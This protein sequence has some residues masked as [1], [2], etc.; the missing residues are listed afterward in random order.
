MAI[1][2]VVADA[3]MF[4][5]HRE[6]ITAAADAGTVYSVKSVVDAVGF[7]CP[8]IL[9]ACGIVQPP[10]S[11]NGW[12]GTNDNR[13]SFKVPDVRSEAE[14]DPPPPPPETVAGTQAEPFHC[15]TWLVV[16]PLCESSDSECVWADGANVEGT[17]ERDEYAIVGILAA[18]NVPLVTADA[19][20]AI[21]VEPAVVKRPFASTVNVATLD[22]EP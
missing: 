5:M 13:A 12:I 11:K 17:P 7:S 10:M 6:L 18:S 2:Y 14:E 21:D 20:I 8:R 4:A 9:Y 19:A 3:P 16:A 15:G 22:A 1:R